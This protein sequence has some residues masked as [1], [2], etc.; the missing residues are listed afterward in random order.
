MNER[1]HVAIVDDHTLLREG[2]E[3][4]LVKDPEERFEVTGAYSNGK[5]FIDALEHIRCDVVILDIQMPVK[6]GESTLEHL[7]AF[8]PKIRA[9]MLSS[10]D[11]HFQV[12]I[13]IKL[14]AKGFL[15]KHVS[16]FDF[17][18]A[19]LT[20]RSGEYFF[21]ELLSQSSLEEFLTKKKSVKTLSMQESKI[22]QLVAEGNSTDEIAAIMNLSRHTVKTYRDR[23]LSK[24]G[25]SN[26]MELYHFAVAHGF[27]KTFPK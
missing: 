5:D 18:K 8:F 7:K 23:A 19:I 22:I 20:V 16:S 21:N 6:G 10:M 1:V 15:P 13:C 2:L 24:T 12:G 25:T 27:I 4:I 17:K 3:E 11:Q 26:M 14:G 9:L